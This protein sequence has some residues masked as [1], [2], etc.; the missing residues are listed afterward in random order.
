MEYLGAQKKLK[1]GVSYACREW[2]IFYY[3][4]F[5]KSAHGSARCTTPLPTSRLTELPSQAS[6][7]RWH[8]VVQTI[9]TINRLKTAHSS[10]YTPCNRSSFEQRQSL[11]ERFSRWNVRPSVLTSPSDR[12]Q[13]SQKFAFLSFFLIS[14][15]FLWRRMIFTCHKRDQQDP[16]F[17]KGKS[18]SKQLKGR[19][20]LWLAF[21]LFSLL[22]LYPTVL[23]LT[24]RQMIVS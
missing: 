2:S 12:I 23:C 20:S 17:E 9:L 5:N 1:S 3:I 15:S 11:D 7:D 10:C 18:K 19:Q 22:P 21:I 16:L 13:L 6:P 14:F 4:S 24:L 8:P